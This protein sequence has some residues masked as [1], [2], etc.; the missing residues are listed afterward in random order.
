MDRS[1][2]Y[3]SRTGRKAKK[4][5]K[6]ILFLIP[7]VFVLI[8][9]LAWFF[10]LR[11]THPWWKALTRESTRILGLGEDGI[12][13]E[14]R[15]IREEVILKKMEEASADQDWRALVPEYPKPR[16]ADT[17]GG[18]E[19][20]KVFKDSPEFKE[21]EKEFLGYLKNRKDFL[22]PELP[23]PSLKEGDDFL[24]RRDRGAEKVMER[25]LSSKEK[26][27]PEKPLEENLL[28]GMKGP[29][30]SRKI[31]ERPNPPQIK[32][33]VEAEIELTLYV[34]P[35]GIVDRVIPSLKGDA[36]LERTAIQYLKRWRFAP[37]PKD[38]PQT[39]QWGTLPIRFRLE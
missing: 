17:I 21:M 32:V 13:L 14:E 15:R 26:P 28:L 4:G 12:P 29:L 37:L 1:P 10:V 2:K 27:S 39:E 5:R 16:K 3:R 31:V 18:K 36:E 24:Q 33:K 20:M 9:C 6:K 8:G 22:S 25:L 35:S 23:T 34:L 38:N 11:H 7:A 19:K 30:S